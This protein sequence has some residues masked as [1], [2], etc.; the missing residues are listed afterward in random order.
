[1]K[2]I[3]TLSALATLAAPLPPAPEGEV[4]TSDQWTTLLSI[5]ETFVP[6][7]AR[8]ADL[9]LDAIEIPDFDDVATDI[10]KFQAEDSTED[11]VDDFLAESA[12]ALPGFKESL[13]RK[14]LINVPK[15]GRDGLSF[16]LTSLNTR[17]G[18]YVL[19]GSSKPI[20]LQ[21]LATRMTITCAWN[22][23][24]LP[25]L[26]GLHRTFG[27]LTRSVWLES[28]P[29]IPLLLGFPDV[30]K[31]VER[32]PSY[33]F[34]FHDFTDEGT[35]TTLTADAVIIGSGC[36]AGVLASKLSRAGLKVLVLEKSYHFSSAHFPMAQP[37]AGTH[38]FENGGNIV[39]DDSSIVVVAGSTFGGGGT[40]N[41]SASLQPQSFVRSEWAKQEGLPLFESSEFQDCLDHVCA[42]MGVPKSTDPEGLSKISHN[43]S[44]QTLLEGARKLGIAANIVPQNTGNRSHSCGYCSTGCP[45]CAKQGPANY[46][47]PDAASHGCEFIEGCFV[48]KIL[49]S[50][51]STTPTTAVGVSCTW[52]SRD[53]QTIRRLT[54]N[55]PRVIVSA[56]TLHS[57]LLLLRSGLTNP[58][59]GRNLHLHPVCILSAIWPHRVNPWEGSI[60]TA[61][62]TGLEQDI[63]PGYGP[64]LEC[65]CSTPSFACQ[66]I[67]FRT[68]S[69]PG[70][71]GKIDAAA[72]VKQLKVD[73]AKFSHSTNFISLQRDRDSGQV[74]PDPDDE[75]MPRIRYSASKR[76]REGVLAGQIA[77]ARMVYGLGAVEIDAM[78]PMVSR[79]ERSERVGR[80]VNDE[81]FEVWLDELRRNG[82]VGKPE[83]SLMGSAH[84]MGTCRMSKS[85]GR[86][87]VDGRGKV[88][89]CEGLW[90]ADASVFPSAS[91]VNPMVTNMGISEWVA[92]GIVG[93]LEEEM[94]A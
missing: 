66:F 68:R 9:E 81:A 6:H 88:W 60:L 40:I 80:E 38:L 11:A 41:W 73:V 24:Y 49:F 4:F 12:I 16:I 57:P 87:V 85:V 44:N 79:W 47:L 56:G 32:N 22:E 74:Y 21:P 28:S 25:L 10:K 86:G 17:V 13:R 52:A 92:R 26:R 53:R 42:G 64:K 3:E 46:W 15:S 91:G 76:D 20:H 36:G 54:I 5:C 61:A 71:N 29:T 31:N 14:F 84:Q 94:E 27:L 1:M 65:L 89:G 67:P 62:V 37:S 7:L 70:Q 77:A 23:S 55:A 2:E 34:K 58:H 83:F 78:T 75:R 48:D 50:P 93:G 33:D 59:I 63:S 8:A 18:S 90:V 45:S 35:T 30:P 69:T 51:S 19:T 43:L 39:S 82:V 72:A